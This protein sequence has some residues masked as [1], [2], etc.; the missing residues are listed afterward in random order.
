MSSKVGIQSAANIDGIKRFCFVSNVK[1]RL[2]IMKL[3]AIN[4]QSFNSRVNKLPTVSQFFIYRNTYFH[5]CPLLSPKTPLGHNSP[6]QRTRPPTKSMT[7]SCFEASLS[8]VRVLLQK[9]TLWVNMGDKNM[10]GLTSLDWKYQGSILN[11]FIQCWNFR[12]VVTTRHS[13]AFEEV[14]LIFRCVGSI[15]KYFYLYLF[16]PNIKRES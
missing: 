3:A 5:K 14:Y 10:Q 4:L 6:P 15:A 13:L 12:H 1:R 8:P 7:C 9:G 16:V 11:L 2:A